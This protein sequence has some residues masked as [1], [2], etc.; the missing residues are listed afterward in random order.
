MPTQITCPSCHRL[1]ALPDDCTARLLSCPRCLAQIENPQAADRSSAVQAEAPPPPAA[2]TPTRQVPFARLQHVADVDVEARWDNR[3]TSALTIVLAVLGS[4]GI[5]YALLGSVTLVRAGL[6]RP[7]LVLLGGLTILTL[8]SGGY[9]FSR[10]PGETAGATIGRALLNVLR[11]SGVI[12][13]VGGLLLL[14]AV[15][16]LFVVCLANGGKC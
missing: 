14:A 3:G 11:I 2:V 4:L 16:L 7:V 9:V 6:Y 13:A 12:V 5:G 10:N 15:I 1:L 8:I